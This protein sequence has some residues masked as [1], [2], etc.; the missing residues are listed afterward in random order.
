MICCRVILRDTNQTDCRPY[1]RVKASSPEYLSKGRVCADGLC[2]EKNVCVQKV[3]DYVTR[4]W[5]VIQKI[6]ANS[7]GNLNNIILSFTFYKFII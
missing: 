3:K 6:D 1:H 4:F 5:K 7:F 2:N